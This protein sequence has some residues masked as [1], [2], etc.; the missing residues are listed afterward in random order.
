MNHTEAFAEFQARREAERQRVYVTWR[1]VSADTGG[2]FSGL[3]KD[4]QLVWVKGHADG[5]DYGLMNGTE[6]VFA[7]GADTLAEA[8]RLVAELIS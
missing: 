4:G 1:R 3:G 2:G 7:G 8:K 5:Y 6:R